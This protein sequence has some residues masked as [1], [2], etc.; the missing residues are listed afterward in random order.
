MWSEQ[1]ELLFFV[2]VL[3]TLTAFLKKKKTLLPFKNGE[4]KKNLRFFVSLRT[5]KLSACFHTTF[6]TSIVCINHQTQKQ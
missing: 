4:K 1:K 2:L 5:L 3:N 6:I